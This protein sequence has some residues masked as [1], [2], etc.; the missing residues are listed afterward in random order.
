MARKK[1]STTERIKDAEE[2][3]DVEDFIPCRQCH[4]PSGCARG[5]KCEKGFK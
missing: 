3:E 4:Y 1:V 2:H 5:D